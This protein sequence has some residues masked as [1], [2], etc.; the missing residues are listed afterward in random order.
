MY[1]RKVIFRADAGK[2][3][4]FGHFIRALALASYLNKDFE[5]LFCTF[6]PCGLRPSEYQ[7]REISK[8][9]NYID[10][11]ASS[12][13]EYDSKFLETLNGD[14]IV[15]LDNY[16]FTTEYQESIKAK[17]YRLVCI[18][19][20][21][22]RHFV[23][24][25]VLTVTPTERERFSLEPYTK[26][27]NGIGHSFLREP[28]LDVEAR[29]RTKDIKNVVLAVGGADP[30]DL[31]N[32]MINIILNVLPSIKLT[33][34]SGDT[35]EIDNLYSDKIT[36]E[37]LLTAE[38]IVDLFNQS[39]MGIFPASTICVEALACRLPVAVGWYVDNQKEFYEYG[40]KT[41]LFLPLGNFLDSTKKMETRLRNIMGQ[42]IF[43]QPS[44][45]D[46][47]KGKKE[48]IDLFKNL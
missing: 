21:H 38:Q 1:K 42:G 3:I 19:D 14:E 2:N 46:F 37:R 29:H 33:V 44:Y 10:I 40:V 39:D 47:K 45:I 41:G 17:C 6:N 36:I 5:C 7:L 16:Y 26:F 32:K 23:A 34:I 15:V 18:D 20:M 30:F 12:Y 48:L 35:V 9:C 24:D 31:T 28:F 27:L 25:A 4:G 43:R 13:E 22:D 11:K 8:V